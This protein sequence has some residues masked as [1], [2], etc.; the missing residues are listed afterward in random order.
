M[1]LPKFPVRRRSPYSATE[2]M[3]LDLSVAIPAR[4]SANRATRP[5]RTLLI[6]NYDSYT[7]NLFQ[8]LAVANECEPIVVTNDAYTWPELSEFQVD[9]IVISPGPGSPEVPGDFGVCAD[10]VHY[11]E[12]PILGVCLGHQGIGVGY[13]GKVISAP[14]VMHGRLSRVRHDGALFEGIPQGFE[15]VRY[16]SLALAEPVPDG[17]SVTARADDG[18]VMGIQVD[19]RP[20]FGV[21]FHPESI[22]TEHGDRIIEN[23]RD[24]TPRRIPKAAGP[25]VAGRNTSRAAVRRPAPVPSPGQRSGTTYQAL[26]ER[27]PGPIDAEFA[28]AS[29]RGAA[30]SAWLDSAAPGVDTGRFSY[31]VPGGDAAETITY[32]AGRRTV[33]VRRCGHAEQLTGVTLYDHLAARMR[34]LSVDPVPRVPFDFVGGYV[35][36]VGYECKTDTG[37][38]ATHATEVE[39][40]AFVFADRLVVCDHDSGDAYV[41]VLYADGGRE[42]AERD[43]RALAASVGALRGEAAA[44]PPQPSG[45]PVEARP[46]R[47]HDQ[48]LADIARCKE[49]LTAGESYE[50]CLTNQ[51]RVATAEAPFDV[52]RRLR[53]CNPAP[54][55]AFLDFGETAVSSSSPECFMRVREGG[56][57]EVKPIKGTARRAADPAADGRLAHDLFSD[58]KERAENLMIVDLL[59]NDLGKVC[60]SGSVRVPSL[61][62]I[63]TFET[64]HQMVSTIRGRLRPGLG[65]AECVRA[66]FPGGSMTGAPKIRTMQIIDSIERRARGVYS[67]VIGYFGLTGVAEFSIVI[68]TI[69]HRDGEASVGAGGAI[70]VLSDPDREWDEVLLK[71]QSVLRAVNARV[72]REIVH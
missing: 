30:P 43:A 17:V 24:L 64:V 44:E 3:P 49:F 28:F 53:R 68:R 36:W 16:H 59:R 34:E 56:V 55:G 57:S 15:V 5:V 47:G 58:P 31:L 9:N 7:Y 22:L 29:L 27:V 25:V 32:D 70:T 18:T 14:T 42:R 71:A 8:Q 61:M 20:V 39:D 62:A 46:D 11:A 48:Y 21:Q 13:G 26:V 54:Y 50:I 45:E 33:T 23:F 67:G 38:E 69:V 6:D 19:D 1:T 4:A 2:R 41:L 37:G 52:Y 63:E 35:G 65:T 40:A 60:E 51:F 10:V 12:V 66:A 72:P